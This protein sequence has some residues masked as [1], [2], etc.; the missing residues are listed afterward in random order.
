MTGDEKSRTQKEDWG[1]VW[2]GRLASNSRRELSQLSVSQRKGDSEAVWAQGS[3][4][5]IPAPSLRISLK[6]S[7]I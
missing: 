6:S 5:R 2:G 7:Q 1:A 4:K 3:T